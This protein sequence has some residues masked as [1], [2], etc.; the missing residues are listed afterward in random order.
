MKRIFSAIHRER[1]GN[2]RRGLKFSEEWKRNISVAKKGKTSSLKGT[3]LSKKHRE[4]MSKGMKGRIAWNIGL[5]KEIHEGI[6]RGSKTLKGRIFSKEHKEKLSMSM[7]GKRGGSKNNNWKGGRVSINRVIRA[8]MEYRLWRKAV[9]ERDKYTCIW[10]RQV[11]G[12]LRADHIKPFSLFPEL[13]FAIDNGRTLCV[14]CH[15]KTNTYGWKS[16][17]KKE[18]LC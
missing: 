5:T 1:L 14:E 10:C 9:F 18:E 6:L 8:S 17:K 7:R 16:V 11:G 13:R 3:K 2:A 4:N 15:G 12:Q